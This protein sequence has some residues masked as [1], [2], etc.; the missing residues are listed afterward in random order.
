M[1][2]VA[3]LL[4]GKAR[5]G[6]DTFANIAK[7]E[8]ELGNT[9]FDSS[10]A[11]LAYAA[12]LK[13]VCRRN[14]HYE[15]KNL[16]RDVLINIGD[17][18]RDIDQDIF[19]RPT[20]ELAN[21]YAQMGY[22]IIIITDLRFQNEYEYT[23]DNFIGDTYVLKIRSEFE[24]NGVS[25]FAKNHLGENLIL[26]PDQTVVMPTITNENYKSVKN[27]VKNVIDSVYSDLSAT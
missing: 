5:S 19:A 26:E 20:T 21:V 9:K 2:P 24:S 25:E 8:I 18:M 3:I 13:D 6:K 17:D 12:P 15:D 11:T 16:D 1:K 23:M 14:H 7:D 22:E 10:V 4:N 27:F